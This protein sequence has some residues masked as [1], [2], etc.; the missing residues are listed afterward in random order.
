ME[1][2]TAE[3]I[4]NLG[5]FVRQLGA[6]SLQQ[7][8]E[9]HTKAKRNDLVTSVDVSNE[10]KLKSFILKMRPNAK[11]IGE[12]LSPKDVSLEGEVWI[13]D[14]IDGTLNFVK[15][16]DAFGIMLAMYF[17]SEPVF[18][19]ILDVPIDKL[20]WGQKDDGVW[21]NEQPLPEIHRDK[22]EDGL[23]LLAAHS[24][25]GFYEEQ[26]KIA[27]KAL[28]F[29]IYDAASISIIR[30]LEGKDAAYL[31]SLKTWDAAAGIAIFKEAGLPVS[32]INGNEIDILNPGQ[33]I[34]GIELENE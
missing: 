18:G 25:S 15:S 19:M 16:H 21:I 3:Q 26:I 10:E 13:I 29:R 17:D 1:K 5:I 11:F 4:N 28:S 2:L 14:P 8:F 34:F 30:V 31:A 12:E 24:F 22:L 33:V 23:L 27:K 6:E 32:T 7:N 9:V 20:V